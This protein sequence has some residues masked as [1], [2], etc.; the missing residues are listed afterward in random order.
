MIRQA[1]AEWPE[2]KTFEIPVHIEI[3][4]SSKVGAIDDLHAIL[5]RAGLVYSLGEAKEVE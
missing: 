2:T 1:V 4:A 3:T 5:R